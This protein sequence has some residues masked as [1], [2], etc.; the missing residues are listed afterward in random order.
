MHLRQVSINETLGHLPSLEP[1]DTTD[2]AGHSSDLFICA[3][4]FEDRSVT[5]PDALAAAGYRSA[6]AVVLTYPAPRDG[7]D[8]NETNRPALV[9]ALSAITT[10]VVE[11]QLGQRPPLTHLTVAPKSP[12]L[13]VVF[14]ISSASN[15]WVVTVL[16]YLL[17]ADC[18]LTL[19]YTEA[20]LYG[21]TRSEWKSNSKRWRE[22]DPSMTTEYGV[23]GVSWSH[24]HS[25]S[26]LE[27]LPDYVALFPGF[28][29]GRARS[30]L[31]LI[32]E[33]LLVENKGSVLWILGLPHLPE[34]QWR[35]DAMRHINRLTEDSHC[36]LISTFQYKDTVRELTRV[37]DQQAGKSNVTVCPMGSKLQAVGSALFLVVH[38]DVRVVLSRP[39][40]VNSRNYSKGCKAL[41]QLRLG[42][43]TAL[44]GELKKTGRIELTT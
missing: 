22:E 41:W 37:Y 9:K 1:L 4:G 34:N 32:D 42:R 30:A 11:A 26:Q 27:P 24:E 8:P 17:H 12:P 5:I 14:D 28:N 21:P 35:T 38:P 3:R 44:R 15:G 20:D 33:S 13:R 25:G 18:D 43:T 31:D 10:S 19:T 29:P 40:G 6:R 36:A 39:G 2:I 16:H 7:A 23:G